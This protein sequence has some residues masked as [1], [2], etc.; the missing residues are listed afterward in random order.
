MQ[1]IPTF[2]YKAGA[3]PTIFDLAPGEPLPDGWVDSPALSGKLAGATPPPIPS[4][5]LDEA[6]DGLP[7][8]DPNLELEELRAQARSLGIEVASNWGTRK[9]RRMI[10]AA[11]SNDDNGA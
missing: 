6:T 3:E 7:P 10:E 11:K 8:V 1:K 2:G 9:L 4:H 5:G